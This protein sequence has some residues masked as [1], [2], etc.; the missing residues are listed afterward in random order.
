MR[1]R[2][3]GYSAEVGVPTDGGA[4]IKF[5]IE[6]GQVIELPDVSAKRLLLSQPEMWVEEVSTKL[7]VEEKI[8][9]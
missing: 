7:K 4:W 5:S 9:G 6:T 8:H 2:R 1:V 3:T